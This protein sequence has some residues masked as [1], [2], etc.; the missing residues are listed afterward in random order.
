LLNSECFRC[1]RIC[2]HLLAGTSVF[3]DGERPMSLQPQKTSF[4]L[5]YNC[6]RTLSLRR[7]LATHCV[8]TTGS[9]MFHTEYGVS[10]IKSNVALHTNS[11]TD[12]LL[13]LGKAAR[14]S[15]IHFIAAVSR[16]SFFAT[17]LS[18][19]IS[20]TRTLKILASTI[21]HTALKDIH[22]KPFPRLPCGEI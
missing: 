13:S 21:S 10:T 7:E 5:W 2:L 17:R 22:S 6:H 1:K 11:C 4:F 20:T 18:S 9:Q 8:L 12:I 15:T 19:I 3:D 16:A 14:H